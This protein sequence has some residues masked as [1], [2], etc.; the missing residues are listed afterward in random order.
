[1]VE[2]DNRRDWVLA[3]VNGQ[4]SFGQFTQANKLDPLVF[5]D[6]AKEAFGVKFTPVER[7]AIAE[8]IALE[9]Q[10]G[11]QRAASLR[12]P[13]VSAGQAVHDGRSTASGTSYQLS[14]AA[15]QAGGRAL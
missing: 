3:W 4:Q 6:W 14:N 10:Q 7:M 15:V 9:R 11:A 1:M 5:S 12:S 2:S 8:R 13:G